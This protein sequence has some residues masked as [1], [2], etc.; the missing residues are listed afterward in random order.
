MTVPRWLD[1]S[2]R[3][4]SEK[5]LNRINLK[6][7]LDFLD[8]K[9]WEKWHK[10]CGLTEF[11]FIFNLK[12]LHLPTELITNERLKTL[13]LKIIT[14]DTWDEALG[15]NISQYTVPK[16]YVEPYLD[17][18][19]TLPDEL[20]KSH[21]DELELL[22]YYAVATRFYIEKSLQ[23]VPLP[24]AKRSEAEAMSD[25]NDLKNLPGHLLNLESRDG[26]IATNFFME[27][28][29]YKCVIEGKKSYPE[30]WNTP[31][32]IGKLVTWLKKH[33][34]IAPKTINQLKTDTVVSAFKPAAVKYLVHYIH[35]KDSNIK[36]SS[37][38]NLCG[39]WGCRLV[40]ALSTPEITRYIQT[41]PNP[42][43]LPITKK[44]YEAY[45]PKKETE[46]HFYDKPMEDLTVDQLCPDGKKNQLV[47]FSP[48]YFQ[49]ERY[50]GDLQSHKRYPKLEAWCNEFLYKSLQQSYI[51]LDNGI[52]AINLSNILDGRKNEVK[53][54]DCLVHLLEV[55][56]ANYFTKFAKPLVYPTN[57]K[58][59]PS[60]IFMYKTKPYSESL[61]IYPAFIM[62][63]GWS[64]KKEDRVKVP[65][66][67]AT[68]KEEH[69]NVTQPV[70]AKPSINHTTLF[71]LHQVIEHYKTLDEVA[72]YYRCT[73]L[74]IV[75]RISDWDL[76]LSFEKLKYNYAISDTRPVIFYTN[77]QIVNN[78]LLLDNQP[79]N[80]KTLYVS[81]INSY[82]EAPQ[83]LTLT[84]ESD[85]YPVQVMGY[86]PRGEFINQTI[87]MP[88]QRGFDTQLLLD[89]LINHGFMKKWLEIPH[90]HECKSNKRSGLE[91]LSLTFKELH[92]IILTEPNLM[93]LLARLDK[94]IE[95]LEYDL[96]RLNSSLNEL[97]NTNPTDAAIR[98]G[99]LYNESINSI[100][101]NKSTPV[102]EVVEEMEVETQHRLFLK[103]RLFTAVPRTET[104]REQPEEEFISCKKTRYG[105]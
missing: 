79:F 87:A 80:D 1:L 105:A 81:Y 78:N 46:A 11:N 54:V 86:N 21:Q 24:S 16:S 69:P 75:K 14:V 31:N 13:L 71:H 74:D 45:D 5:T 44:I 55:N 43:L 57:G 92:E 20:C 3:N 48:P 51:A 42:D 25:Y 38:L 52:L 10:S 37:Y 41:D 23:K 61:R 47:F 60:Y 83:G 32:L 29:R 95:S 39:G 7:F 6:T 35:E 102:K 2:M 34:S 8:P 72:D 64:I 50:H 27:E 30:H 26:K 104:T 19:K 101:I 77:W 103:A 36:I 96:S 90:Y 97:T 91:H 76:R 4:K 99:T 9:L 53:L 28:A 94:T 22:V 67:K 63:P 58:G 70:V 100:L 84:P 73:T 98:Y 49:K 17:E 88:K 82:P 68:K 85:S 56:M 65:K 93:S 66:L 18:V 89:I 12:I 59:S 62:Q 33:N 15:I 40:G